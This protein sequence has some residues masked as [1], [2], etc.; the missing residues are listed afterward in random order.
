M[1]QKSLA[2]IIHQKCS[3][4]PLVDFAFIKEIEN[5]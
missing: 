2:V 5:K 4:P 3:K 1:F